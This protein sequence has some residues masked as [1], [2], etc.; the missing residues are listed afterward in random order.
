MT[1]ADGW[2]FSDAWVF[3]AVAITGVEG[4]DLPHLIGVADAINHAILT[5]DEIA[6]AVGRFVASGLLRHE[7]SWFQLTEDGAALAARRK[8]GLFG[9]V[10]SVEKL[11]A[12]QPLTEGRWDVSQEVVHV[13]FKTYSDGLRAR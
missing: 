8:G 13:A 12:R 1:N 7:H 2:T 11:L 9:Q 5:A 3:T 4:C 6:Q 10:S